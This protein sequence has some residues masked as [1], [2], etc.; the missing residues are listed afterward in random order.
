[1][2]VIQGL[3]LTTANYQVACN[4]LKDRFGRS[5]KI[6]FAHVQG[7]LN[8]SLAPPAKGADYVQSLW[9]LQDELLRHIRSLEGLGIN[10]DQYGVVL[11]PVTLSRLPQEIRLQ[12]SRKS[13]GHEGDLSFLLSFLQKEVT[14]RER[15]ETFKEVSIDK[16]V[17]RE[18]R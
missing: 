14:C 4:L 15:S 10:G 11:T 9:R 12:W 8:V 5:E 1:M 7:L 18:A 6:I 2:S 13:A 3:A 17:R 16:N